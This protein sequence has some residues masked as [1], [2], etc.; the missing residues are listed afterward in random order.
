MH[1]LHIRI[2]AVLLVPCLIADSTFAAVFSLKTPFQTAQS[3][4]NFQTE[5]LE[6]LLTHFGRPNDLPPFSGPVRS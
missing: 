4:I 5:A 1:R 2:I 6:T 3:K